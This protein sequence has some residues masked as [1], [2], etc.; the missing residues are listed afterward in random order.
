MA[1]KIS[2]IMKNHEDSLQI[3]Y[4][5][6]QKKYGDKIKRNKSDL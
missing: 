1:N 6:V 4:N 2:K 3:F 5:E